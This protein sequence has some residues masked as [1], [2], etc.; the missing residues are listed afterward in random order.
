MNTSVQRRHRTTILTVAALAL[1]LLPFEASI[2]KTLKVG[3]EAP[4]F[5]G[6]DIHGKSIRL[7][8]YRGKVVIV[9]FWAS[10]CEPC[11]KELPVLEKVQRA[12]S[13]HGLQVLAVN[14][15][16]DRDVFRRITK[17]LAEYQLTLLSDSNGRVG[18]T[19]GVNAIPH[20]LLIGKD[21][22]INFINIGYGESVLDEVVDEINKALAVNFSAAPEA[23]ST[24][25]AAP[26]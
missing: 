8:D 6:R 15:K 23:T 20:M 11:R 13:P 10:W 26:K 1:A 9:S 14:W 7:A 24:D 3:D 5:L 16:E 18:D 22:R 17:A 4:D 2:G 12:V 19:Y 25:G 21:G